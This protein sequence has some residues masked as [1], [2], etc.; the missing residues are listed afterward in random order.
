[1][2][3]VK[4]NRLG[5]YVLFLLPI[6]LAFVFE[7]LLKKIQIERLYNFLENIFFTFILLLPALIIKNNMFKTYFL[8]IVY[9]FLIVMLFIETSYYFIFNTKFSASSI[10]IASETNFNETIEF[11]LFYF[12]YKQLAFL[13]IL[14]ILLVFSLARIKKISKGF[15]SIIGN[16]WVITLFVFFLTL[17]ISISYSRRENLPFLIAKSF[18]DLNKD[19]YF[20][21]LST[22][23]DSFGPFNKTLEIEKGNDKIFVIVIGE[24][25]SKTHFNLYGYNRNTTPLLNN[26]K[27]EILIYNNVI[28][29]HAYTTYALKKALTLNIEDNNGSIIQLLNSVGYQTY[30]LSNQNPIGLYESL[31]SKIASASDKKT[32]LTTARF[33]DNTIYDEALIAE[34][35]YALNDIETR[36]VIFIHLQGAHFKYHNRYPDSFNVFKNMPL[37]KFKS[38]NAKDIINSYDNAILYN[39]FVVSSII[40]KVKE[41]NIE[42]A[43]LY[44]SDHGEEVYDTMDF[45]GHNDDDVGSLPMFQIPFIL[46]QSELY[47][48]NN[49][50]DIELNRAYM[51]D[52][53]FH[54]IAILCGV[55]SNYVDLE[56]SIFS[57]SFK[58]KRRAILNN[59]DYDSLLI[60]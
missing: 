9:T 51:T 5:L 20:K 57:D 32:F 10:F 55:K 40:N 50:I 16:F 39:D 36:K 48:I 34:L 46:W 13:L 23:E 45:S 49:K 22:Y 17:L 59:K 41:K 58:N 4:K 43:V 30:W 38:E 25:I 60:K 21:N 27:D 26:I 3:N 53:L 19:S 44:F 31:V 8:K 29:S 47:K 56:K 54:S 35:D 12:D 28:T 1:M 24:S 11:L 15:Y 14:M 37:T 18:Y 7:L 6:I 52:D 42:S 2:K 33:I